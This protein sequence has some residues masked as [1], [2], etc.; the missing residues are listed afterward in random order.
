MGKFVFFVIFLGGTFARAEGKS[1]SDIVS[2]RVNTECANV[3]DSDQ[4]PLCRQ[5]VEEAVAAELAQQFRN[6]SAAQNSESPGSLKPVDGYGV[7]C[8]AETQKATE[9]C[10]FSKNKDTRMAI[11][12]ADQ[13]RGQIKAMSMSSPAL[14]CSKMG[15]ISQVIDAAVTAFNVYCTTEYSDCD[16]ACDGDIT[17]LDAAIKSVANT[18]AALAS[19]L[20]DRQGEVKKKKRECNRLASNVQNVIGNVGSF[21]AIEAAKSQYCGQK[22]DPLAELCKSQPSNA[23]CAS[24]T[25]ST[26]CSNPSVAASNLTCICQA[27]RNDSRCT[28]LNNAGLTSAFN[29]TNSGTSSSDGSSTSGNFG[30]PGGDFGEP[31]GGELSNFNP[32]GSQAGG[33][34]PG[35]KGQPNRGGGLDVSGGGGRNAAAKP[36]ATSGNANQDGLN[37]KIL[38]GYGVGGSGS[39]GYRG[40]SPSSATQSPSGN[41]YGG[42]RGFVAGVKNV[43]NVDLRKFL[44]GGQLDPARGIAGV[45]GPDGI[46]GP[47]TNIW[48]K[49]NSRYFNLQPSLLP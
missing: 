46:T 21:A 36:G 7:S 5:R 38:S 28:A 29:N 13:M 12:M 25:A 39:P 11:Q 45:A 26:D 37:T 22:T 17:E 9:A 48:Q 42:N 24:K 47:N 8:D 44:P 18:N 34:P 27:N 6:Q 19:K 15:T 3:V 20:K 10:D 2:E 35:F 32:A 49:V 23:L 41:A 40:G 30:G 16:S 43:Q 31:G 4:G 33:G 1:Y 14:M